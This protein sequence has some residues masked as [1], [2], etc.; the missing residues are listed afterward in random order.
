MNTCSYNIM[1]NYNIE[2]ATQIELQGFEELFG[3]RIP[4]FGELRREVNIP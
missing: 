1:F 3:G 4:Q 2:F